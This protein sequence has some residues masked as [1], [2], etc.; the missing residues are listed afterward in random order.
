MP[1]T[2]TWITSK[3][4]T[5]LWLMRQLRLILAQVK[6]GN[7]STILLHVSEAKTSSNTRVQST[8]EEFPPV[9]TRLI[10]DEKK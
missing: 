6:N 9:N 8:S 10:I 2:K 7:R 4:L 3:P 5:V 1:V